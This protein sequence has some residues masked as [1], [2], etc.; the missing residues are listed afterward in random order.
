MTLP[1]SPPLNRLQINTEFSVPAG[2]PLTALVRG[3]A[4]VPNTPNN[5]A[6]PTTPPLNMLQF[7]GTS[8][9]HTSSITP[10]PSDLSSSRPNTI[11]QIFTSNVVGGVGPF[12]R[13]WSFISGGAGMTI[14]SPTGAST[15]VQSTTTA[16]AG[17]ITRN[18]TL[19]CVVT[20]TGAGGAQTTST[21]AL[22]WFWQGS[23]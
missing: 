15:N 4:Y 16:G 18:A 23:G 7:L 2:T 19:Q 17:D 10:S 13:A 22:N 1:A 3:G 11:N 6:V 8:K 9:G 12:T 14:A 20:D 5:N 21:S